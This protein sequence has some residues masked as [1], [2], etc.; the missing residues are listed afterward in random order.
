MVSLLKD[1]IRWNQEQKNAE[2]YGVG[3]RV[4]CLFFFCVCTR[5]PR[6]GTVVGDVFLDGQ[7]HIL[8]SKKQ[9]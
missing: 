1:V 2:L 3:F 8:V 4:W 9:N 7:Q 5:W 6:E